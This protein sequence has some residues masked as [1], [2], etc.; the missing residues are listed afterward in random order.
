MDN[1]NDEQESQL[2]A[3]K[4]QGQLAG[5]SKDIKEMASSIAS[6]VKVLAPIDNS[7]VAQSNPS[8]RS[9]NPK[10]VLGM[11]DPLRV[12][13]ETDSAL[14]K[15]DEENAGLLKDDNDTYTVV[16]RT[17]LGPSWRCPLRSKKPECDSVK[18]L[19]LNTIVEGVKDAL[20]E[21]REIS[22]LQNLPV[23]H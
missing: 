23:D 19:K 15:V 21:D 7:T 16:S 6:L 10:T 12:M 22:H 3:K 1:V 18:C 9:A 5:M 8:H 14:T 4:V 11:T 20:D 2:S 17:L 13:D